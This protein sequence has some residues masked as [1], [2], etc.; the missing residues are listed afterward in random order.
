MNNIEEPGASCERTGFF[1]AIRRACMGRY[2]SG[3]GV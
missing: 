3:Y 2:L 1:C